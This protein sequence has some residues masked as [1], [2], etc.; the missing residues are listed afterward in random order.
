MA[1]I[2][3]LGDD[4]LFYS[5]IRA[6]AEAAGLKAWQARDMA[7]LESRLG[8]GN[9]G[10][11]LLDLDLMEAPEV[12]A[13]CPAGVPV[14]AYGPHVLAERLRLARE[15]GCARVLPRSAFVKELPE[16]VVMAKGC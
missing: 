7:G 13:A 6:E 10:L 2:V 9:I 15:A 12:L 11:V 8:S 14:V 5:R 16:I 1:D 3:S 4:L